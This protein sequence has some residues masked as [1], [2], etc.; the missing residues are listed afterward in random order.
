MKGVK[1]GSD[2]Y[3]VH[4]YVICPE[5]ENVIKASAEHGIEVPAVIQSGNIFAC[6]FHPEKSGE[7]GLKILKNFC[8]M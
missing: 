2:F 6:Q 1:E 8:G 5:D 7:E 3:F 4:S